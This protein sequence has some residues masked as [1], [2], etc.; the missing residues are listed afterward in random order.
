[1]HRDSVAVHLQCGDHLVEQKLG[2]ITSLDQDGAQVRPRHFNLMLLGA[3]SRQTGYAHA[4][5]VDKN[6]LAYLRRGIAG[7]LDYSQPVRDLVGTM[8]DVYRIPARPDPLV[9]F[10]G[11]SLVALTSQ[12]QSQGGTGDPRPGDEHLQSL[13]RHNLHA[14]TDVN[15]SAAPNLNGVDRARSRPQ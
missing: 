9:A 5:V 3:T 12:Q 1:V 11:R 13:G 4:A 10:N 15:A 2:L 8:A 14:S 6:R 7:T